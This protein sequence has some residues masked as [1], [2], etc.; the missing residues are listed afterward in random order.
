MNDEQLTMNANSV[1]GQLQKAPTEFTREDIINFARKNNIRHVSFMY[2][3]GDG[4]LKTL[5]FVL[6]DLAYLRTILT[7]GERVDGSS[8]FSFIEAASS[9][10]YVLPRYATAF[11]DPF[12]EEPTLCM[13]CSFFNRDGQPLESS[14]EHTLRKAVKAFRDTTGMEFEAMGE[15]EYYVIKPAGETG[16]AETG[17]THGRLQILTLFKGGGK[18]RF[19]KRPFPYL[20]HVTLLTIF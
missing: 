19:G 11:M 5:N 20:L 16:R 7:N 1:I 14:P 17:K 18:R 3:G 13:L 4:R 12:S 2:P 15:L 8:L 9:D 10:L 6:S